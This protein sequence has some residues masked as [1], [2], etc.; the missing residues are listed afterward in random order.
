MK[1]GHLF[2]AFVF[3][4]SLLFPLSCAYSGYMDIVDADFLSGGKK[5]EAA[6]PHDVAADK[7]S[8]PGIISLTSSALPSFFDLSL[9]SLF[10]AFSNLSL[11]ISP[12]CSVLRR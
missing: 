2:I 1:K 9:F 7:P 8:L 5:Y 3:A 10:P 11:S 4:T 12:A 6:D